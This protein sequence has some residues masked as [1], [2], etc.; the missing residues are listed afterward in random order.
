VTWAEASHLFVPARAA[1]DEG[2]APPHQA[3]SAEDP[4]HHRAFD[5]PELAV[6]PKAEAASVTPSPPL[7]AA[8]QLS[9]CRR[10][11]GHVRSGR[12]SLGLIPHIVTAEHFHDGDEQS[13]F[14]QLILARRA[15]RGDNDLCERRVLGLI[16]HVASAPH[17][18][19]GHERETPFRTNVAMRRMRAID[20]PMGRS[21]V[22]DGAS[23][24]DG[25]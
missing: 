19:I 22:G 9:P 13:P 12:R 6:V 17:H 2:I 20:A 11:A 15:A 18:M 14:W 3:E 16:S 23:A 25:A 5:E 1:A 8:G 7:A 21:Y 10:G 24:V 4:V